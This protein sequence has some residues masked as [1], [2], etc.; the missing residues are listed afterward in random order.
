[1]GGTTTRPFLYGFPGDGYLLGAST[2]AINSFAIRLMEVVFML[3]HF[4]SSCETIFTH[5]KHYYQLM[6]KM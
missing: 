2:K 3:L 4:G 6:K 5:G 1:M